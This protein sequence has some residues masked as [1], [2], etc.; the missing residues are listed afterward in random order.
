MKW[1]LVILGLVPVLSFGM[2]CEIPKEK[3]QVIGMSLGKPVVELMR[4]NDGVKLQK[5][6]EKGSDRQLQIPNNTLKYWVMDTPVSDIGYISYS[7]KDYKVNGFAVRLN[8]MDVEVEK[9][10]AASIILFDLPKNGWKK[11]TED[12]PKYGKIISYTYSCDDYKIDLSDSANGVSL[13]FN[14]IEDKAP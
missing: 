12:D 2:V 1:L 9:I 8:F 6:W 14:P 7:E 13:I 10:K 5:E 4:S 11:K 3:M